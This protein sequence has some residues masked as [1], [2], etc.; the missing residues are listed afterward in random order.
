MTGIASD[1]KIHC[2]TEYSVLK[3]VLVVKPSFMRITEVINETQKHYKEGN[4]DIPLALQQH[5]RF[6]NVLKEHGAEVTQL[7]AHPRLPEQVFT[8]DIA[9]AIHD[10][11]FLASM[12]EEVRQEE[13]TILRTWL[14]DRAISYQEGI[15]GSIEGG[16]VVIDSSTIWVGRSNRTSHQAVEELL[17]RLPSFKVEPLALKREILHLDC[18][19]NIISEDFALVYPPAFTAEGLSRLK[20]RFDVIPVTKEEQFQMGPNVL[21]I[22]NGKVISL[23]QNERLNEVMQARGFHV[24]PVDFSEIIKSGGSFRCCT[25]PLLRE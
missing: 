5:D 3:S 8:R 23:P 9:F 17:M 14:R 21:S 4:I 11:L 19:F 7:P 18:V 6:V 2:Q 10:Q 25:L 13:T 20:A 12:N 15:P 22:G 16:D 24:I 1:N